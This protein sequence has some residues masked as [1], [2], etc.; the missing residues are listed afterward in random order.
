MQK[1]SGSGIVFAEI[2]G[3]AYEYNLEAGQSMV[4]DTGNLATMDETVS[5]DVQAVGGGLKNAF[6]G[7][8]GVFNT[9]VTGPG[10][11]TFQSMPIKGVADSLVEYL[12]FT[13]KN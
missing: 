1:A 3:F 2:D 7:G 13:D 12:P 6:L 5:M 11:V 10:K 9:V 4:V 8:E